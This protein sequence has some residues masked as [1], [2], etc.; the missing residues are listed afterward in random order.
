ML[1]LGPSGAL[2]GACPQCC[3]MGLA[4]IAC[5]CCM[6]ASGRCR[7]AGCTRPAWFWCVH[8]RMSGC[9]LLR[10]GSGRQ[11]ASFW[12]DSWARAVLCRL[13]CHACAVFLLADGCFACRWLLCLQTAAVLADGCCASG[14]GRSSLPL[15]PFRACIIY[16]L[17][18]LPS[19]AF[20]TCLHA[21]CMGYCSCTAAVTT[22]VLPRKAHPLLLAV[23]GAGHTEVARC[24]TV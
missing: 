16:R 14:L 18:W 15:S 20:N 5:W 3:D 8:Q 9:K 7:L 11:D 21:G 22:L 2:A 1:A 4:L 24:L 13:A 17:T 12:R 23:A 10:A 19:Q 6:V